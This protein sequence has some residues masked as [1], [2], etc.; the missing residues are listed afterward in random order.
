MAREQHDLHGL[1]FPPPVVVSSRPEAVSKA[2]PGILD[3]PRWIEMASRHVKVSGEFV[4][5]V[6]PGV[7][8]ELPA[9]QSLAVRQCVAAYNEL[10]LDLRQLRDEPQRRPATAL[11]EK[12]SGACSEYASTQVNWWGT[13]TYVNDCLAADIVFAAGAASGA[14]AIA[15]ILLAACPPCAIVAGIES[16]FLAIYAAWLGWADQH[17]GNQGAYINCTW[18][19]WVWIATIC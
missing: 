18:N 4:A 5:S 1:V 2:P 19:G 16:A 15:A 11:E 3:A 8:R 12:V 7:D 17:C 14:A 9:N 13:R 6:D 10:P